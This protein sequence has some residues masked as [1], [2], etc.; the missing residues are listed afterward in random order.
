MS[1]IIKTE[2]EWRKQ[3]S[4]QAFN[5][6]REHGTEAPFTGEF[7]DS[8]EEGIYKCI[9]CDSP[10]FSS[11]AK[12]DSGTGWPSYY[13]AIDTK[14]IREYRDQSYGME[15]VEVLCNTCDAHLG[16]VFSDGP[17]PTRLRYCIN[18]VCLS[19]DKA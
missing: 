8:K 14:A 11:E 10:L 2:Q 19:L 1:K 18:S 4:P 12:F 3:L 16:H 17:Q 13:E 6:A 15:R 5:V 9:C 7:Y